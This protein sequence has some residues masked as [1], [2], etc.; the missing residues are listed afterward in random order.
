MFCIRG[1]FQEK[2]SDDKR[3]VEEYSHGAMTPERRFKVQ[4]QPVYTIKGFEVHEGQWVSLTRRANARGLIEKG[5]AKITR[6][7]YSPV[8]EFGRRV[9]SKL[10]FYTDAQ[11]RA[12]VH[13]EEFILRADQPEIADSLLKKMR[14]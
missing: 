14:A 10:I 2:G 1:E 5:N 4:A 13:S 9:P 12:L 7:M 8:N 3:R 6:V 11:G